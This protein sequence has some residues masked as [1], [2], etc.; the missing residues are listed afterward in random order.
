MSFVQNKVY[1]Y[2]SSSSCFTRRLFRT[3][4]DNKTINEQSFTFATERSTC[5]VFK[6]QFTRSLN[7]SQ[8]STISFHLPGQ[9]IQLNGSLPHEL[10]TQF[11]QDM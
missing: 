10:H 7:K 1:F 11:G 3:N 5:S 4:F 2:N 8:E 9:I 6:F